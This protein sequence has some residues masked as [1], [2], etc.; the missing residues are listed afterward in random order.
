MSPG[1]FGESKDSWNLFAVSLT[2]SSVS[3]ALVLCSSP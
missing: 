1:E 3:S 2:V